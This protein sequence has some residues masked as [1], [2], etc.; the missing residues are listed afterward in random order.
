MSKLFLKFLVLP[1]TLFLMPFSANAATHYI[2]QTGVD[3]D[4]C[5]GGTYESPWRTWNGPESNNCINEGDTVYFK[6][7]TYTAG[8]STFK[9]GIW[10]IQG[11]SGN[12]ITVAVDPA[13]GGSWPVKITGNIKVFG[14]HAVIDGIEFDGTYNAIKSFASY[15]TYQNNY[16]HSA[17]SDCV[18][19]SATHYPGGE[20]NTEIRFIDNI[21][22]D[23]GEDAID[24]TGAI[25]VV[26]RGNEISDSHS[27]QIKGGTEN[28]LI[29]ENS[30][31][32]NDSIFS[33]NNMACSYYCGS[34]LLPT[35]PVPDRYVAKNVT[36]RNNIFYD[37]SSSA[38]TGIKMNGW[39]DSR[40]YNNTFYNLGNSWAILLQGNTA[41][42]Q[43]FDSIAASYCDGHSGECSSCGSG[44]YVI[45]HDPDNIQIRNNI[46]LRQ[47][48][49]VSVDSAST[50][51]SFSNNIYWNNGSSM[52]FRENGSSRSSVDAFTLESNS[53]QKA[54][55]LTDAASGDFTLTENSVAI[56][57]GYA[58][59]AP[60]ADYA[61]DSRDSA[62]DIGAYEY[63]SSN[64]N[65]VPPDA[66]TGIEASDGTFTDKVTINWNSST[67]ATGYDV[68][69]N[70]ED[71]SSTASIIF[72]TSQS[73]SGDDENVESGRTY[74]YWVK[75]KKATDG[76]ILES[77]FSDVDTGYADQINLAN[78]TT[79]I[80][81]SENFGATEPVENLWDGEYSQQA[82]S[83]GNTGI[84][85]FWVEFDLGAMYDLSMIRFY[86][87]AE[88]TWVSKRY[89]VLVKKE[90]TDEYTPI[91]DN[92][93]CFSS[94]MYQTDLSDV[95]ARY[96]KLVVVGDTD[97]HA[98]QC[99]E[100]K[101]FGTPSTTVIPDAPT[102]IDASDGTYTD[103]VTISW[104]SADGATGYDVY[105]NTADDSSTAS[106]IF[107]TSLS[108][109]GDDES[110]ESGRTYYYWVKA[111]NS[112]DGNILES[113]FS[114]VDSGYASEDPL[115][116]QYTLTT[117][118][119]GNGTI[120]LD[121][122]SDSYEEGTSVT[123]TATP[124]TDYQF[125]HWEGY[126]SGSANPLDITVT[127][128][129]AVTA[130]FTLIENPVIDP[131][132]I[133][134]DGLSGDSCFI[135]SL[136]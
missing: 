52:S 49:M 55:G 4:D 109:G 122:E 81:D 69:R 1:F 62:P 31:H 91:I 19:N 105:R 97:A 58:S 100:F 88:G 35:L 27:M 30:F 47:Q 3:H 51:I 78:D 22:A 20:R 60:T 112:I 74:Y 73:T 13:A 77:S 127:S 54:P 132:S 130:V 115:V 6:A 92:A 59:L 84:D 12:N 37:L 126:I 96:I 99:R 34:P 104:D 95:S 121:P 32:G 125:D 120:D 63:Q 134:L 101:V 107:S 114:D 70:T 9:N 82:G 17:T 133:D 41:G 2:S 18:R 45:K 89:S 57:N 24:N 118:T 10:Y 29:E 75:A 98:T 7:G 113:P 16:I 26:I 110:V 39:K 61:G 50:N 111:K 136:F 64:S 44:C 106:I 135:F 85:S 53:Y 87:D 90:E 46:F 56:D 124:S 116:N 83:P 23:C 42:L 25:N 65:P 43:Y 103:K 93:D 8:G 48:Q 108:T 67:G 21:I 86:G 15:I 129:M 72:S 33:G 38:T 66:P 80:G 128:D 117:S 5:S 36:I 123:I 68:Y 102:G 11:E 119:Q 131:D 71:D 94:D 76:D 40:V 28:I 14:E 79:H